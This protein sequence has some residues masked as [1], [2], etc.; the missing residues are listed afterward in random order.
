MS[1]HMASLL[2]LSYYAATFQLA[3]S[4]YNLA[5]GRIAATIKLLN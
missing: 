4:E 3:S 2:L 1:Y 5:F